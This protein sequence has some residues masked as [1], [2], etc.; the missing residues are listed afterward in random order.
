MSSAAFAQN[1]HTYY[2]PSHVKSGK[3]A[4][5]NVIAPTDTIIDGKACTLITFEGAGDL[6][7]LPAF[8]G[9]TLPGWL[10]IIE[11]N[12]GGSGDFQNEPSPV[13]T[14]FWLSGTTTQS[15]IPPVPASSVSFYYSSYYDVT[16]TAYDM[17]GNQVATATGPA[18]F[19]NDS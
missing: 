12:A 11:D 10:S 1:N 17:N 6:A 2:N 8:D 5:R 9:I 13:T 18:N 7:A 4:P 14:A 16:L 15:I 3:M 19:D